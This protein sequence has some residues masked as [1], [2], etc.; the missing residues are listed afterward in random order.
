MTKKLLFIL[1]SFWFVTSC[2][3]GQPKTQPQAFYKK[4]ITPDDIQT[5]TPEEAKTYHTDLKYDYEYRTGTSG[6]YE[7]NY[8]IEG[9]DQEGDSVSGVINIKG[10]HGAGRIIDRDKKN[11]DIHVEWVGYGKLKGTDNDCNEYTLETN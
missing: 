9:I 1:L 8:E 6:N 2:K 3:K 4:G 10:K 11:I 7:Y 5:I